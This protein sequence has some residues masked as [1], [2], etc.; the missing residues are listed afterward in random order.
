MGNE[1]HLTLG[2]E[3]GSHLPVV[4]SPMSSRGALMGVL[5]AIP[6]PLAVA[7]TVPIGCHSCLPLSFSGSLSLRLCLF[8]QLSPFSSPQECLFISISFSLSFP[9]SLSESPPLTL[10]LP[11]SGPFSLNSSLNPPH[12]PWPASPP[13]SIYP[14]IHLLDC[15]SSLLLPP[16]PFPSCTTHSPPRKSPVGPMSPGEQRS[17][18]SQWQ[19]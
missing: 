3:P 11:V 1:G 5:R 10:S 19:S 6:V 2:T 4:S 7:P 14:S 17:Q 8:F 12:H 15:F 18:C 16:A 9:V 13:L